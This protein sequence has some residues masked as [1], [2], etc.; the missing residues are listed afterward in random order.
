MVWENSRRETS[1]SLYRFSKQLGSLVYIEN[2][3][4]FNGFLHCFHHDFRGPQ[5]D[6]I[7]LQTTVPEPITMFSTSHGQNQACKAEYT[8][9]CHQYIW[10]ALL[11]SNHGFAFISFTH[12]FNAF[13][14]SMNISQNS[15]KWF[16]LGLLIS[17]SPIQF[18]RCNPKLHVPSEDWRVFHTSAL[19]P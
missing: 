14:P 9:W 7:G 15:W 8:L 4:L 1:I 10:N 2:T 3:C 19:S 17:E 16:F 5:M 6:T 11:C 13:P 12:V 18:W